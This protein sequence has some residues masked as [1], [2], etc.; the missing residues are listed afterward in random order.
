MK[1]IHIAVCLVCCTHSV[2]AEARDKNPDPKPVENVGEKR[3]LLSKHETMA[4]F[5]GFKELKCMHRTA[6]CPDRCTHGGTLASFKI[7][8][9][10]N[11]EKPGK[12]G[13]PKQKIY[14]VKTEDNQGNRR[15]TAK[16][17]KLL[18]SLKV[19]DAVRLSWN[20]DY[21]TKDRVSSPERPIILLEK[22][23]VK[24]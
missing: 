8:S 21:V 14:H 13:D 15:V 5:L 10:I 17:L 20:H 11:Y 12:Y 7:N 22:V 9:Y 19:G 3:K 23:A 2:G 16:M 4:V 6:F 1:F 24:E 18:K